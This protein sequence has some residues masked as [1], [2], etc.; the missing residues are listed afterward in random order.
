MPVTTEAGAGV[1][2]KVEHIIDVPDD[3]EELA[4]QQP[5]EQVVSVATETTVE[6]TPTLDR[7]ERDVTQPVPPRVQA[8][9][10]PKDAPQFE[11][12]LARSA[13]LECERV[14]NM[15]QAKRRFKRDRERSAERQRQAL[16][17][18]LPIETAASAGRDLQPAPVIEYVAPAYAVNAATARGR[19]RETVHRYARDACW[20]EC[21][22]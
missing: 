10:A 19:A 1:Q 20:L 6:A 4:Q 15:E 16:Q 22:S 3:V 9:A 14:S 17:D 18:G 8:K 2:R 13:R 11:R 21:S 12:Q 5:V 7:A